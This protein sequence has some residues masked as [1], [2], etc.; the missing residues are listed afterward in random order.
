MKKIGIFVLCLTLVVAF[1]WDID[2]GDVRDI[3]DGHWGRSCRK[4]FTP[5]LICEI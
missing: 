2:I 1:H 3:G 5:V 4:C